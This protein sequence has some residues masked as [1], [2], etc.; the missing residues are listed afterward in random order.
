MTDRPVNDSVS[1][2][3]ATEPQ[4][5]H[6]LVPL[7]VIAASA[8][9]LDPITEILDHYP[10]TFPV[11]TV[12]IQHLSPSYRSELVSLLQSHTS[13]SVQ[14][15]RET[16]ALEVGNIYVIQPGTQIVLRDEQ[17]QV[18]TRDEFE[19]PYFA[20]DVFLESVAQRGDPINACVVLLSGTGS[21]GTQGC[22]AI[23]QQGGFVIVQQ[24]SDAKFDGMP[25][26][27]VNAGAYDEVQPARFIP[28]RI[29]A[30]LDAGQRPPPLH[31][32]VL[33]DPFS[34]LYSDGASPANARELGLNPYAAVFELLRQNFDLDLNSYK[35][36]TIDR[37]ITQRMRRLGFTTINQY[38]QLLSQGGA[39]LRSLFSDLMIGVTSFF[40]NPQ[41]F[42][43]LENKVLPDLF[44]RSDGTIKIWV[45]GCSTGEEAYSIGMLLHKL[46]AQ[47][48]SSIEYRI[49]ATD[50][51]PD[52]IRRASEGTFEYSS[53]Q[54]FISRFGL[55]DLVSSNHDYGRLRVLPEVRKNI[56]FSVQNV[57]KHSPLHALDMVMCRNMLIYLSPEAQRKVIS[58]F[59]FGLKD[60]AI[61]VLGESEGPSGLDPYFEEVDARLK[62]FAK[63][64]G[65][66]LSSTD[67]WQLN[68][69]VAPLPSTRATIL[70]QDPYPISVA[71]SSFESAFSLVAGNSLI[72]RVDG[73]VQY[74]TGFAG[75]IFGRV[76]SGRPGLSLHTHVHNL[77]LQALLQYGVSMAA[78]TDQ[79]VSWDYD[80]KESDGHLA[81]GL[82]RFRALPSALERQPS[83]LVQMLPADGNS[84][85]LN[86]VHAPAAPL[87][88][89][90]AGEGGLS[91]LAVLERQNAEL[92]MI[93][94]ESVQD[95]E[96]FHEELQSANEE[97]LSSNEELQSTN[98]E[99][100]SVNEELHS[101]NAELGEKI[102]L[103]TEA[104]ND[105]TNVLLATNMALLFLDENLRI[106]RFTDPARQHF[107]LGL[108][109]LGRP[110]GD[111]VSNLNDLNVEAIGREVIASNRIQEHQTKTPD[112]TWLQV[113]FTP[114]R[115]QEDV[116]SGVVMSIY[117]VTQM[118]MR[119]NDEVLARTQRELSENVLGTIYWTWPDLTTSYLS[120]AQQFYNRIGFTSDDFVSTWENIFAQTHPDDEKT[121]R[122]TLSRAASEGLIFSIEIRLKHKQG[123]Y[124]WLLC[125]G[126]RYQQ[127]DGELAM[128]GMFVDIDERK[129]IE[130]RLEE[131][132]MTALHENRI[133]NI[134]MLVSGVAHELN[135]PLS[136]LQ[137]GVDQLE[138]MQGKNTLNPTVLNKVLR[139][140]K[141]SIQ[142]MDRIIS[143]LLQFSRKDR[144]TP[145][146][147]VH[148]D[149]L[150][151]DTLLLT[152]HRAMEYGVALT[153]DT[154]PEYLTIECHPLELAQALVNMV[155]N[156]MQAAS[157]LPERWVKI[158]VLE[159]LDH[160]VIQIKDSGLTQDIP[161]RERLFTP[162]YTTKEVG[163]GTGLGLTL[164]QGIVESHGGTLL[165]DPEAKH[166][167]FVMRL[168][169]RHLA[170][171]EA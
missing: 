101:V 115:E 28:D 24:L 122:E 156:A 14:E 52:A 40:R 2:E 108:Q 86:V 138:L 61:L 109:D 120:L 19:R 131:Q 152:E 57:L 10:Q 92:R 160:V 103:L 3:L 114:Y 143:N 80:Y 1:P 130:L 65:V 162:F 102:R 144:N 132:K 123:H 169:R 106:R 44:E 171:A 27:V 140:Q 87:T 74:V 17:I 32:S 94:S 148:V 113:V 99:L 141:D 59:H 159:E 98:E 166:T 124:L 18:H 66:S 39:E 68:R 11:A 153:V 41:V 137:L 85:T 133:F 82:L 48:G 37:R 77:E 93:V 60:G 135:N 20:I 167:T 89:L 116:V 63:R 8:G 145:F 79:A 104:N 73:D 90:K 147:A 96:T 67:R 62:V 49:F 139:S 25:L 107:P 121:F 151:Q 142:R 71:R 149:T 43:L 111:L 157:V 31:H 155:S 97:L 163:R 23:R 45:C 54:P 53:L 15:L 100:Q 72:V 136:A 5:S 88:G 64:A 150:V 76:S 21:D 38:V 13:Q 46:I 50:I 75:E 78:D 95:K 26:S 29:M 47:R 42:E 55:Q 170:Q 105:I 118:R 128:L 6:A 127:P 36:G 119:L 126:S 35:I 168:P 84:A 7:V 56:V 70:P 146:T 22:R 81:F 129:R 91:R 134:G 12:V 165:L 83:I 161:N 110:I 158:H 9:G 69:S 154:V 34:L 58:N 125:N 112:G 30:W 4:Q 16:T 164:S 33:A 51:N 117:D